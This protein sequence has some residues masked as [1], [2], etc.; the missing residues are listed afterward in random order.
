VGSRASQSC[1]RSTRHVPI[2]AAKRRELPS[3]SRT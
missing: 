2:D 3:G 1:G